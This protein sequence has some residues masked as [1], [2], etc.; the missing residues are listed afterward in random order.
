MVGR[1]P[2]DLRDLYSS[3]T[4]EGRDAIKTSDAHQALRSRPSDFAHV[5]V[6]ELASLARPT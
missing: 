3:V 5:P 6:V 2:R 1:L 4:A